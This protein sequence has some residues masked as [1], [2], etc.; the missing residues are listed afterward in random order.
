MIIFLISCGKKGDP[1]F[2]SFEKPHPVKEISVFHSKDELIISWSY[3]SVEKEKIK[4]F[5]IDKAIADGKDAKAN[6]SDFKNIAFIKND[7]SS[8]IDK[9]F[10]VGNKY[11]YKIRTLSLRDILSVDSPVFEA[12]ISAL[13]E[14]PQMIGYKI[15]PDSV[16]IRWNAS[17]ENNGIVYNLYKSFEKGKYGQYPLNTAPLTKPFYIDKPETEKTVYYTVRALRNT[18]VKDEGFHSKELEITIMAFIPEK[19]TGLKFAST[20]DKVY[21]MWN[22]NKESW[23]SKYRIYKR[24]HNAQAFILIG[25]SVTPAF[26]DN[27]L[28]KAKAL[29][30]I[31]AVGPLV[32]SASSEIIEVNPM[33]E[34]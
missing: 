22:E 33:I 32:E 2:K 7:E 14:P 26:T 29:Y 11:F 19:P 9:D 13:P 23:V 21:L 17:T 18:I 8:F 10:K 30:Y 28:L 20:D 16:E 34:R 6:K 27:A 15:M 12:V 1:T 5:Y 31:T 25:E 24:V 4:G 3:P